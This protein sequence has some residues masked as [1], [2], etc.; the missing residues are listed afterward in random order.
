MQCCQQMP[1]FS[2]GDIVRNTA[3]MYLDSQSKIACMLFNGFVVYKKDWLHWQSCDNS[4]S[5]LLCYGFVTRLGS[6]CEWPKST[7]VSVIFFNPWGQYTQAV[8]PQKNHQTNSLQKLINK[9]SNICAS[10]FV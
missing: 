8:K 4:A 1:F 7:W 2:E 10:D 3:F 5:I 6:W 9:S